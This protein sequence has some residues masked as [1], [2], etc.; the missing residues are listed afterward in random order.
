VLT[1]FRCAV[2]ARLSLTE[3]VSTDIFVHQTTAFSCE[4]VAY[5]GAFIKEHVR[6]GGLILGFEQDCKA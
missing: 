3:G 4:P 6:G 5:T 2:P 1:L